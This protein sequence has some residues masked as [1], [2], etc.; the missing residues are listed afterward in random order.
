MSRMHLQ[1]QR[2]ACGSLRVTT[3]IGVLACVI[4][5]GSQ[6]P[7][8]GTWSMRGGPLPPELPPGMSVAGS[9][10]VVVAL[11]PGQ[12]L[13]DLQV[14]LVWERT[15]AVQGSP[16]SGEWLD[17]QEWD[18]AGWRVVI[19]TEDGDALSARLPECGFSED[20]YPVAYRADGLAITLPLV[21]AART[22]TLH[23]IVAL[24]PLPEPAD[25]AAWFAVGVPHRRV[26]QALQG[27]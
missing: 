13:H 26:L 10:G 7:A 14:G 8:P 17:A 23:F 20:R 18:A 27:V 22:T 9:V 21:P 11:Q 15:P 3:P 1:V 19:G 16:A 24:N 25:C 4:D 2:P 12:A 5:A 6:S